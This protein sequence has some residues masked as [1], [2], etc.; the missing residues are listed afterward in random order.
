MSAFDDYPPQYLL[1]HQWELH[2][3]MCDE[4]DRLRTLNT[5]SWQIL[6][7]LGLIPEGVDRFEYD[8]IEA[9]MPEVLRLIRLGKAFE[10]YRAICAKPTIDAIYAI[11]EEE[12]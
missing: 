4:I 12:A 1:R 9:R 6:D 5:V 11:A 8:G 2:V 10:H 3:Q 7:A